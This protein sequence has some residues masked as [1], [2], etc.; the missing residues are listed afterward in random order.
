MLAYRQNR[1]SSSLFYIVVTWVNVHLDQVFI[2]F[3]WIGIVMDEISYMMFTVTIPRRYKDTYTSIR[4]Y[5]LFTSCSRSKLI[6]NWADRVG[7]FRSR[8]S[9]MD[10]V[11]FFKG[12][13]PQI[14]LGPFLNTLT[15]LINALLNVQSWVLVLENCRTYFVNVKYC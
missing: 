10:K 15:R 14:L 2:W 6:K 11:K 13:V 7:I 8:Y 1:V 3:I 5:D 9:R 12:C 4:L